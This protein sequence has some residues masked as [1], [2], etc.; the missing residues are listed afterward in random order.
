MELSRY[1]REVSRTIAGKDQLLFAA[2]ARAFEII[3]QQLC[4]NAGLDATDILNRLRH[5]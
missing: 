1:L 3:P 2:F 4:Y 5:K